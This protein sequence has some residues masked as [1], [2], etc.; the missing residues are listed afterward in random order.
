MSPGIVVGLAIYL[1]TWGTAIYL[2]IKALK[3][4]RLRR[5]YE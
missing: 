2:L 1:I 4:E 3:A 5:A